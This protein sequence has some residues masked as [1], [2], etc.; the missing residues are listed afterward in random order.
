[1]AYLH[2]TKKIIHRDLK[3]SNI[4]LSKHGQ[5]KIADFG[6]CSQEL[7]NSLESKA[8]WVGTLLYMSVMMRMKYSL[9]DY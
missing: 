2:K 6:V 9:R 4:L 8:S 7:A 5:V 3:P 1:M